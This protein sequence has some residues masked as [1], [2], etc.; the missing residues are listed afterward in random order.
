MLGQSR[1]AILAAA[2]SVIVV[3]ALLPGRLRRIVALLVVGVCLAPA[4]P[5][6]LDVYRD[7]P[8][9][10]EMRGAAVALLLA[11]L[12]AASIWALLVALEERGRASGLRPRRV[13]AIGVAALAVL[14]AAVG[15]AS[16]GRIAELRRS[17]STRR[18]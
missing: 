14:A 10:G 3:L 5:A 17:T 1:G 13:V 2:L 6:L 9:A 15:V 18:S 4:I 11:A 8:T 12:A 16:A 7:G